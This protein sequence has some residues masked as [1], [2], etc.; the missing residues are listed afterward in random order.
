M[1]NHTVTPN[2]LGKIP[3]VLAYNHRSPVRGIGVSDISDIADAQ[4]FVYNLTSEVEQSVR[5]NGHPAL[6]KTTGT[7]ASAGAGAIVLMED[8]LDPGLKPYMLSVETDTDSIYN[9]IKHTTEV[10]D[11]MGSVGSIRST[12]AQRLSGVAQEQ[13][14]QL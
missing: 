13:E 12:E 3:A 8:N 5:T 11:K 2:G 1:Q 6:A 14:F 7:E 9:A 10:I 4:K